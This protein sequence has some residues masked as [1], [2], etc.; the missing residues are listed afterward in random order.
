MVLFSIHLSLS[1]RPKVTR[2]PSLTF[3]PPCH[4]MTCHVSFPPPQIFSDLEKK[5]GGYSKV[6][7]FLA[8]VL[9]LSAALFYVG[10]G[11]LLTG[12]V[13]FVYPA[14]ASFKAVESKDVKDDYQWLTYWVV[15]STFTLVEDCFSVLV[16]WIPFYFVL[17]VLALVWLYH[18]QTEGAEKVYVK[19]LEPMLKPYFA[20]GDKDDSSKKQQ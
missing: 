20:G 9:F 12:L 3:S 8:S 1:G 19:L 5:T 10:G 11:K 17:K 13:G 2:T 15:F 16:S 18:P 7:F 14:Y 4:A 6:Y